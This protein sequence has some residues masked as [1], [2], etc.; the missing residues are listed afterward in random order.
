MQTS[1]TFTRNAAL[2]DMLNRLVQHY[3]GA[4]PARRDALRQLVYMVVARGAAPSV[5]LAVFSRLQAVF[6]SWARLRDAEVR[7][8]KTLFIGLPHREKKAESLPLILKTIEER[9]GAL[10]LDFLDRLST[11]GAQRWLEALPGVDHTI[12]SAVLAFSTLKRS[13]LAIDRENVRPIRRLGLCAPGAPLSAVGRQVMEAAPPDW[14]A[15]E[16]NA[17]GQGL[18]KLAARVCH[19]GKPDCG[20]CPLSMLCPSSGQTAEVLSFPGSQPRRA[21][22]G[23]H[24]AA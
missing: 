5:G 15:E 4:E 23:Q 3:G 14:G 13:S 11:D 1:L 7:H 10:D 20:K 16:L 18:Q 6:P 17:L 2:P 12:A 21:A 9:A 19:R 24:N 22:T 8:L